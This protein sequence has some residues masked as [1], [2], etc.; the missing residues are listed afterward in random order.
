MFKGT[1]R[2]FLGVCSK[3]NLLQITY[4]KNVSYDFLSGHSVSLKEG[5]VDSTPS[6]NSPTA[7]HAGVTHSLTDWCFKRRIWEFIDDYDK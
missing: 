6:N 7:K 2:N 4:R 5:G 3:A 1:L